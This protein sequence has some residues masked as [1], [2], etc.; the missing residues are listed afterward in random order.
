MLKSTITKPT[1]VRD[2]DYALIYHYYRMGSTL[3]D[4]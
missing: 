2:W 4:Y 3:P 1:D